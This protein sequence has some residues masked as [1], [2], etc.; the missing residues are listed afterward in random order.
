[1]RAVLAALTLLPAFAMGSE[2]LVSDLEQRLQANGVEGVNAHLTARPSVM[3]ELNQSSA[4]CDPRAVDLAVKLSRSKNTKATELHNESLRIAV[5]ACTEFV[6]SLLSLKEVPKVCASVS[7]WT[8][9][10]T[11]R[12]LRRRI[13]QIESDENLRPTSRGKACSAAY[14]FELQNTRVGIRAGRPNPQSK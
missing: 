1:M 4:D 11:A 12:E 10:Q 2:T 9:S 3:A 7:S 8:V 5:G 14:L 6:L 13:R